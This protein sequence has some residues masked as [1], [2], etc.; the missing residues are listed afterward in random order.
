MKKSFCYAAVAGALSMISFDGAFAEGESP[1]EK[2]YG[3]ARAGKNDCA[4]VGQSCAGS[5]KSTGLKAAWIY[6]PQGTCDKIV[7]GSTTGPK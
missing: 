4:A 7:G 6:V 5:S 2:C 1:N 3:I